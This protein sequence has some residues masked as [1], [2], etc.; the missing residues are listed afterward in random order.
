[1]RKRNRKHRPK[2]STKEREIK[3]KKSSGSNKTSDSDENQAKEKNHLF[4][5]PKLHH[6]GYEIEN[7]SK[8]QFDKK[9]KPHIYKK[10]NLWQSKEPS[11]VQDSNYDP[12]STDPIEL[13]HDRY[14][15]EKVGQHEGPPLHPQLST[16]DA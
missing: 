1:M 13:R 16:P 5:F 8:A 12:S 14:E 10:A 15:V 2:T 3:T 4:R 7:I 9:R 6:F 11:S